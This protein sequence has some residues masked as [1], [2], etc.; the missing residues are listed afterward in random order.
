M[1]AYL[2]AFIAV[3]SMAGC[4]RAKVEIV[5]YPIM[6]TVATL[7]ARDAK[8]LPFLENSSKDVFRQVAKLLNRFDPQSEINKLSAL[9]NEEVERR[10]DPLVRDCY[11]AAFLVERLS[12]GAFSPRWRGTNTLDLGAIAKGYALDLA[13]EDYLA[14]N[15]SSKDAL[16]DLG[17]NLI[18]CAGVWRAGVKSPAGDG[19]SSIVELSSGE[20]LATSAFYYRGGHIVDG[21]TGCVVSNSVASVTVLAKSAMWADALSTVLF[22]LGPDEGKEFLSKVLLH[23]PESSSPTAVLWE[24]NGGKKI[25]AL[26]Q[27]RFL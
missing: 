21:R 27:E 25:F 1:K 12:G 10:A 9:A 26:S 16:L 3:L 23:I 8:D 19:F 18:S 13:K 4:S 11:K 7:Q 20:A 2:F 14:K 24:M 6:G 17:G 22:V 15:V 5:S